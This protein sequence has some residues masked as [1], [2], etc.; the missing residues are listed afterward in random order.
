M[1]TP[2]SNNPVFQ[3]A[4]DFVNQTS[5]HIFL[6]G[7]AGTG[8]TTF[9][10]HIRYATHKNCIVAA[11]TGVAAIN[12]GGMTLHSLFQLPFEPFVPGMDFRNSKERFRFSAAKRDML[13]R[14]EL[15]IIDEVSM[16][17]ADTLDSIDSMLRYIRRS[18]RPF[19]GVQMLYIGDMFQLPPVVKE[20]EWD[21]LR[22]HYQ[23]L[24][25]FH[26]KAVQ[27][28]PPVYLELKK[29]YRQREQS[30]VDLLNR[31]RN[32]ELTRD[33]LLALNR[34]YQAGFR[35]PDGEKY[36]TLTTRN[37]KADAVNS[38]EL[39][40]LTAPAHRFEGE[41]RGEFPEYSLP[42]EM[43]LT[44][45]EGAQ[46]MFIKN[47]TGE[48]RRYYN[49]KLGTIARIGKDGIEVRLEGSGDVI[50][51]EKETWKNIRYSLNK[52]TAEIEEEELGS[53]VQY[54][55]RLAWAITIHKS[56]GLTFERAIIDTGDAFAPGQAYVALS[57][58]TS[59]EGIVLLSQI[60]Q[61]SVQTDSQAVQL[62]KSEK[63]QA[64]LQQILEKEKKR[65][66]D[67]RLLLYFDCKDLISV[68]HN[69]NK[70]LE[71]KIS[72]D[73]VPAQ[74]LAKNMLEQAYRIQAVAARFQAQLRAI[75]QQPATDMALLAERCCKAAAYFHQAVVEGMLLPLQQYINGFKIKKAKTFY[76]NLCG[77]ELD[78]KLFIE[79][80]K[81]V[82]YNDIPLAGELVLPIPEREGLYRTPIKTGEPIPAKTTKPKMPVN[83]AGPEQRER[84]QPGEQRMHI[85][86]AGQSFDLF[87]KG[88]SMKEIAQARNISET[89]VA[90]H[91][92]E[93]VLSGELPVTDLVPQEKLSELL[94]WVQAAIAEDNLRLAPIKES[95]DE[96]FSYNDI[97]F[98][99]NYCLYERSR[100][101]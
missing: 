101:D 93:F 5:Q 86:S 31:V 88:L 1:I 65:F 42:T 57:R 49:G 96:R 35:P 95:V 27:R 98:V 97:R 94:P 20:E 67:E 36:I 79:N 2:D 70:L 41:I 59:L 75:V 11:P 78:L 45:K 66:W 12:A 25:F 21:F 48:D 26:A 16:L 24:F 50:A 87:R 90:S 61:R 39:N 10:K 38:R 56:Q 33:D 8:K 85:P 44:L 32:D 9:L 6:T 72:D 80:M 92:A 15:L 76:K 73:Y 91:L 100:K 19:G 63:E 13:Q 99:M 82:R 69:L 68:P 29:V 77:L 55:V 28:V 3:L 43:T 74:K 71:E 14:L 17:R 46:I 81:K 30:F 84:P 60:T 89:T 18:D 40:R 22:G 64:E 52:E 47:D 54:P 4:A 53:F 23:S 34:Q 83:K 37:V 62:S 58:C 7:K 51:I